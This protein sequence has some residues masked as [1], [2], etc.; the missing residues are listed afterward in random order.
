MLIGA[1]LSFTVSVHEI[2]N[3]VAKEQSHLHQF[4][5]HIHDAIIVRGRCPASSNSLKALATDD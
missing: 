5:H 3:A 4:L 1:F 2:R